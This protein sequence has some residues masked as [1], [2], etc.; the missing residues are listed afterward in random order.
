MPRARKPIIPASRPTVAVFKLQ[1]GMDQHTPQ[2]GIN[3]GTCRDALNFECG[4]NGGYTRIPG[5][6]RFDGRPSPTNASYTVLELTTVTGL[7][8]GDTC[9]GQTSGATATVAYIDVT[10][11]YLGLTKVT[12]TFQVGE[13][14]RKDPA[15]VIGTVVTVGVAI[16]N[17]AT[18]AAYQLAASNIYRADIT[19]VPGSGQIRG[20]FLDG[21]T[22]Y[23][24]RNNAGGTA[25]DLYKSSGA[26]WVLVP[27]FYEVYFN[28]ASGTEPL[29]GST[30]TQGGVTATLK[31]L[32]IESGTFAG[33]TA[34]GR[35][36]VTAPAGGSF[37]AGAFTAGIT[38]TCVGAETAITLLPG[39]RVETDTGNCG[40]GVRVYGADGV[41]RGWEFANDVLV[42]INT[43]MATDKPSHVRTHKNHLFFSFV[44]SAQHSSIAAPYQWS[45]VT[46]AGELTINDTITAFLT[47]PGDAANAA[48]A[49]MG[50]DVVT[51]LYGTSSSDWNLVDLNQGV[52]CKAYSA[53][54][55]SDAY[56]MDDL[57]VVSV[58]AVQSYGNF[59]SSS[60][61][62]N[63]RQFTQA[64]RTLVSGS[65]I[66]REKSQYRVFYSDGW[67]LRCTIVNNQFVGAMPIQYPI[68]MMVV[69]NGEST[70]GGEVSYGGGTD[71]YVY[72][73]DIG[74]SFDGANISSYFDLSFASQNAERLIKRY[75]DVN[76]ELQGDGYAEF[77]FGYLLGWGQD[78]VVQNVVNVDVVPVFWDVF[79][80][81]SFFFDGRSTATSG[82]NITGSGENIAIRI[83]NESNLWP[84]WTMNSIALRFAP[85]RTLRV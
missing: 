72:R 48:L 28:T 83:A 21:S 12:G 34:A 60:L 84:Q 31:R 46:G 44:A 39:G 47:M 27:Y 5:Y 70:N 8:V 22:V 53:Q 50:N 56:I 6:E 45:P 16:S 49:I 68:A 13:N 7:V 33:G 66:N 36:I 18:L 10:N 17:R 19:V 37:A 11:K 26:G 77:Q 38:A 41:N 65:L 54:K 80:W 40:H 29:E 76:F 64:R 74:T 69:A 23:A 81:D 75:Y 79:V 3:P 58:A 63:I 32:V 71:G 4:I 1:G 9:N 35:L 55:L 30:I 61:T 14:F 85:R 82:G 62:A 73:L 51:I 52:G 59:A 24:F 78:N 25:L 43:G 20:V 2:I 57:G 67:E 15:T 42:P